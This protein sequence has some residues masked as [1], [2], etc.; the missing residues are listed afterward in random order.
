L[1]HAGNAIAFGGDPQRAIIDFRKHLG[2]YTK[3][4]PDGRELR[5]KLFRTTSLSDVKALLESYLQ[6]YTGVHS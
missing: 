6:T 5:T 1:E 4:L 2:W 3:G